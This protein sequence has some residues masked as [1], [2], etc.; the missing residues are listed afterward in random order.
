V[1]TP[2]SNGVLYYSVAFARFPVD[3]SM[4]FIE[5]CK[6]DEQLCSGESQAP[7]FLNI[8]SRR[9]MQTIL[10]AKR[11]TQNTTLIS[12]DYDLLNPLPIKYVRFTRTV[13]PITKARLAV[14]CLI[15]MVQRRF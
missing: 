6:Q 1:E 7:V 5:S 8:S 15:L 12:I 10:E 2:G 11:I 14:S 13:E 3:I 9:S 4:V